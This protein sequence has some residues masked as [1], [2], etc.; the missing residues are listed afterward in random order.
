MI[1]PSDAWEEVRDWQYEKLIEHGLEPEDRLLDIG[2]GVL[3]GGIPFIRYLNKG[4]YYGMDISPK[5]LKIARERIRKNDMEDK[6]PTVFRNEDL[7][8][9]DSKLRE[10]EFEYILAQSVFTHL[11]PGSM[12]ECLSNLDKILSSNGN[13]LATFHRNHK[14][15]RRGGLLNSGTSFQYPLRYFKELGKKYDF[16]IEQIFFRTA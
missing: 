12:V 13:L 4:N 6:N 16:Q 5:V 9:N 2:C 1:G 11:P 15:S 10:V 7:K 14:F 3:R 8:F